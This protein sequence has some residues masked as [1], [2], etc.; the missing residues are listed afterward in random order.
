MSLHLPWV[1]LSGV[2]FGLP[3]ADPQKASAAGLRLADEGDAKDGVRDPADLSELPRRMRALLRSSWM[4]RRGIGDD[5]DAL[6]R[7]WEGMARSLEWLSEDRGTKSRSLK[8]RVVIENGRRVVDEAEVDGKKV[9]PKDFPGDFSLDLGDLEDFDG[10]EDL[11]DLHRRLRD[12]APGLR[13]WKDRFRGWEG[14]RAFSHDFDLPSVFDEMERGFE[15]LRRIPHLRDADFDRIDDL[16]RDLSA[17]KPEK[18]D[19]GLRSRPRTR[20]I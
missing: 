14:L 10:L 6:E 18:R 17:K 2:L 16:W 11:A 19:A 1:L 5:F 7:E 3:Q 13:D 4:P 12:F 8:R 20:R 9:D 15:E